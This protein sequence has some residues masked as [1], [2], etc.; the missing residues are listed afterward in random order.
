MGARYHEP[1]AARLEMA[2]EAAAGQAAAGASGH[3]PVTEHSREERHEVASEAHEAAFDRARL[4][5]RSRI[6][7]RVRGDRA[8]QG[9]QPSLLSADVVEREPHEP[10][11]RIR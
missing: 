11:I 10:V 4:R 2:G 3:A 6:Q 9:A 5:Q 8:G 7:L 1:W